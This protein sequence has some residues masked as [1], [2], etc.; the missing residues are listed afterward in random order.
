MHLGKTEGT[1]Y[2]GTEGVQ[3]LLSAMGDHRP[4]WLAVTS[5]QFYLE[6]LRE[7]K[8]FL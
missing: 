5:L 1:P 6:G 8:A 4:G 2:P 7:V 3:P